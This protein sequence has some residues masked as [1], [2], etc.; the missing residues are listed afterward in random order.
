[1]EAT[2]DDHSKGSRKSM[3]AEETCPIPIKLESGYIA[4]PKQPGPIER[5]YLKCSWWITRDTDS[6]TER[7]IKNGLTPFCLALL[8]IKI[9]ILY[10]ELGAQQNPTMCTAFALW[11]FGYFF[12]LVRGIAGMDM[13]VTLDLFIVVFTI[14]TLLAD[15]FAVSEV[16]GRA[17]PAVIMMLDICLVFDRPHV[18]PFIL[19]VSLVWLLIEATESV[20]QSGMYKKVATE[21]PMAC[22]CADPPCA[23]TAING[24][25]VLIAACSVL[26]IDFHLTRRFARDLRVQLGRVKSSIK[27]AGQITAALARFDVD[28]AADVLDDPASEEL[29][30]EMLESF[31]TLLGHLGEFRSSLP[32]TVLAR[33]GVKGLNTEG[34]TME[35]PQFYR[36]HSLFITLLKQAVL[37]PL[38]EMQK[39]LKSPL[40]PHLA[41]RQLMDRA[42]SL[43]DKVQMLGHLSSVQLLV[44][45][46]YTMEGVD[47]DRC[48][49]YE[50]PTWKE[51]QQLGGSDEER[52]EAMDIWEKTE[53]DLDAALTIAA[54]RSDA[55]HYIISHFGNGFLGEVE[56]SQKEYKQYKTE[57][58]DTR[59]PNLYKVVCWALRTMQQAEGSVPRFVEAFQELLG[60]GLLNYI[61]VLCT[62]TMK[63]E[64]IVGLD[65]EKEGVETPEIREILSSSDLN[66]NPSPMKDALTPPLQLLP[67]PRGAQLPRG[68]SNSVLPRGVSNALLKDRGTSLEVAPSG[69]SASITSRSFA[70]SYERG[71]GIRCWRGLSDL[72]P[73]TVEAMRRLR[74]GQFVGWVAPTS[75]SLKE[76]VARSFTKYTE[77]SVLL[78]LR[79]VKDCIPLQEVSMYPQ[80]KEVLIAPFSTWSV[81]RVNVEEGGLVQ[82][83]L[84]WGGHPDS[85]A[86]TEAMEERIEMDNIAIHTIPS[87]RSHSHN[88]YGSV[89]EG[90]RRVSPRQSRRGGGGRFRFSLRGDENLSGLCCATNP[91]EID[92]DFQ[93]FGSGSHSG[94]RSAHRSIATVHSGQSVE[95]SQSVSDSSPQVGA[96]RLMSQPLS[97]PLPEDPDPAQ[98]FTSHPFVPFPEEEENPPTE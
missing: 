9:Y 14:A 11:T 82:V 6:P 43:R 38:G 93:S 68:T 8:P 34:M 26:L 15:L 76:E 30:S 84:R 89:D 49:G 53:G 7:K 12:F 97:I 31:Q 73:E 10:Q 1:M 46:I 52:R 35:A 58:G 39:Q 13:Q 48:M 91:Q 90:E 67:H 64:K 54:Q 32:L 33:H 78:D 27:V 83:T 55:V 85:S 62:C 60:Q 50:A 69:L 42:L 59:N 51:L 71:K 70:R 95:A 96:E 21:P 24:Y 47:I 66:S 86:M 40:L 20:F 28:G 72:K 25:G 22:N 37:G 45:D 18:V 5:C 19:P 92:Q 56:K 79:G 41:D 2:E 81:E 63:V 3:D 57:V 75:V 87:E 77:T 80:E 36:L 17:W 16:R 4:V 74:K 61:A 23:L 98:V 88:S 94:A 44:L 65:V 29:P